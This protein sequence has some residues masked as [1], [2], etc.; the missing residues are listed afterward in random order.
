MYTEGSVS[1]PRP[2][3]TQMC[4]TA[5]SVPGAMQSQNRANRPLSDRYE[6]EWPVSSD[7]IY[8]FK[9]KKEYNLKRKHWNQTASALAPLFCHKAYFSF[10]Y[11][12]V[13]GLEKLGV[14]G[15]NM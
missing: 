13:L 4:T 10:P 3:H 5:L 15:N 7:Y 2:Q 1:S 12:I 14:T 11:V 8:F 9:G 6:K